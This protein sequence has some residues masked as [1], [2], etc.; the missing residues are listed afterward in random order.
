[1]VNKL[2]FTRA[3]GDQGLLAPC[4]RGE[5]DQASAG[6]SDVHADADRARHAGAAQSAIARRLLGEIL[7]MIVLGE[8]EFADGAISVVMAPS[9]WPPAPSG[10]WPSTRRRTGAA[11]RRTCRSPSDTGCRHRCPGACPASGRD[12]PRTSSAAA[13]R[14]PS[15][16]RTPPAPL[17]YDRCGPS[18]PLHRSGWPYA[19]R[20]SRRRSHRCRRRAPR[21]CAPRPRSSPIRTRP[22]RGRSG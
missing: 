21:T 9:P 12:F 14:R 2:Y 22:V 6:R 17:R 16:D 8:I 10:R 7:L 19:R 18:R 3:T 5:L 11:H 20:H 1:M 15:S 4:L 13:R